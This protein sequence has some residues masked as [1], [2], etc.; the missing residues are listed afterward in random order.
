[1]GI[2]L[3]QTGDLSEAD[4]VLGE[5]VA[6]AVRAGNQRL[7]H[8]ARMERLAR[9]MWSGSGGSAEEEQQALERAIVVFEAEG[10]ELGLARAYKWQSEIYNGQ[11]KPDERAQ[12]LE[13]ALQHAQAA[14]DAVEENEIVSYL[15]GALLLVLKPADETIRRY[16]DLLE[17]PAAGP[18]AT[19][20]LTG[21]LADLHARRGNF[22][23]A[24][25]MISAAKETAEEF[26]LRWSEARLTTNAG[27]IALLE[28]DS[29]AA[30]REFRRGCELF[31]AMGERSRRA[32]TMLSLAEAVYE[33]GRLG[34]A[35]QLAAAA[36]ELSQEELRACGRRCWRAAENW[37][38]PRRSPVARWSSQG[39]T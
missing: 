21:C 6:A 15:A 19:A 24:R 17:R 26:G 22:E 10:D 14:G 1:L 5:A 31:E 33:Q 20:S 4:A 38:R 28:G 11:N 12:A 27:S 9:R 18:V 30:E 13:A 35:E 32:T 3:S 39:N 2:A 25:R 36:Q 7:E 16:Q 37:R 23:Q 34:E 8:H 29:G